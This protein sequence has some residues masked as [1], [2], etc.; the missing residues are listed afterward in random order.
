MNPLNVVKKP[1]G[2]NA[3][4]VQV[5]TEKSIGVVTVRLVAG[6]RTAVGG[7]E[8]ERESE[9]EKE[10]AE[11]NEVEVRKENVMV[12]KRETEV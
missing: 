10:T 6:V 12:T 5:G 4:G 1:K 9:A 8:V 2:L 3:V 11:I 7:I